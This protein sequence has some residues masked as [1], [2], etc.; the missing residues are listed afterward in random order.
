MNF[1]F[2]TAQK[3]IF[4][5]GA[6]EKLPAVCA[7][8]AGHWLLT[9]A[10]FSVADG[11]VERIRRWFEAQGLALTVYDKV[12]TEP[13]VDMVREIV[14][15]ARGAGCDGT[16]G[17]GGG[18]GMDAAKAA[19]ALIPNPGQP[20]DYME[21]VGA[22]LAL[23]AAPLPFVALPTT[24]GTGAEATKNAVLSAPSLKMK[25]S[26]RD[27]RMLARAALVDPLLT[28]GAPKSVTAFAGMDAL[29]Q[30]IE[31]YLS[32]KAQPMTDALAV[33]AMGPA[34]KALPRAY[35]DGGDIEARTHMAYASLMSGICLAN[36]G[37]GAV[38]GIAAALSAVANVPHGMACA[39]LLPPVMAW[40]APHV[41]GKLRTVCAA[42]TGRDYAD[43]KDC[44]RAT[45]D[46]VYALAAQLGIPRNFRHL[47]LDESSLDELVR[48]CSMSSMKGNPV[49]M[50]EAA[51]RDIIRSVL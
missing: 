45:T 35:E 4:S 46:A 40:N 3:I 48:G 30:L 2:Q 10:G 34:A 18:S 47:G 17:L 44:A 20:E 24:S 31:A 36:A 49:E 33:A 27:D 5:C 1:T 21:G 29:T 39:V 11:T 50:D 28:L 7:P 16:I 13:T 43:P 41:G 23:A 37:L 42:L 32:R 14:D 22:G 8:L 15:L 38:H 6:L 51:T 19:A 26:I 9:C 25:R 12:E